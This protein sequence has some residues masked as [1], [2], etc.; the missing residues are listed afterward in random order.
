[1]DLFNNYIYTCEG[2]YVLMKQKLYSPAFLQ[3]HV[4][5]TYVFTILYDMTCGGGLNSVVNCC[6]FCRYA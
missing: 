3:K 6:S 1:M 2:P 4:G 5:D